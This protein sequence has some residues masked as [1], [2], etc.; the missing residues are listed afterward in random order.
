MCSHHLEEVADC[1]QVMS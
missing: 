1:V